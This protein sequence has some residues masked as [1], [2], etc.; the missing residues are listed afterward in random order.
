[1]LF[2]IIENPIEIEDFKKAYLE[3]PRLED[4]EDNL[5]FKKDD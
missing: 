4:Q 3:D 5:R 2:A 1:M